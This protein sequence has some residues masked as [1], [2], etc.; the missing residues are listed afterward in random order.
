VERGKR[1]KGKGVERNKKHIL[2]G[3][4]VKKNS[5]FFEK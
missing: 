3:P 4:K 5:L 2:S 1:G